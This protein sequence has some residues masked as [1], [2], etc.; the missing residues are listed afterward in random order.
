[1]IQISTASLESLFAENDIIIELAPLIPETVGSVTEKHLRLIRSGG[2]FVNVGRGAVVDPLE[3]Q[4]PAL[5]MRTRRR[6]DIG[7][8]VDVQRGPGREAL[9]A[10]RDGREAEFALQAVGPADAADLQPH[11]LVRP[12]PRRRR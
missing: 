3:S 7:A 11:G 5:L 6:H 12:T 2:V 8:I 4:E 9:D 10:I 1:M